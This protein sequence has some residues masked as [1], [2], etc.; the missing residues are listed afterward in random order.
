LEYA[1]PAPPARDGNKQFGQLFH[2][3]GLLLGRE[4]EIAVTLAFGGQRGEDSA[5]HP[6]VSRP[7]VRAFDCPFEAQ[8]NPSEIRHFHRHAR[9][10]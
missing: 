9:T 4:H 6:E 10:T 5:S 1:V 3:C 8:S 2:E 7:H